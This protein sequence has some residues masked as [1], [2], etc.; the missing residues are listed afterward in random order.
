MAS[1]QEYREKLSK[2]EYAVT[3][4]GATER[5]F[6]G[7]YWNQKGDGMY[8][9]VCCDAPLFESETKY[10]SG[11]G[12]PSFT[13]PAKGAP[14]KELE[15]RTHGMMRT[16]ARCGTCDA[17]LGHIFDDG[18]APGGLRYCINSAALRFDES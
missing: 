16:E 9:C 5:A 7:K 2:E 4:Q 12:W 3:R 10:D 11:S 13:A 1:D 8:R 15:D 18:P 17:H 6:T 14:V